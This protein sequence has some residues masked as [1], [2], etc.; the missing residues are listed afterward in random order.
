VHTCP[1]ASRSLEL[2]A[3]AKSNG[4]DIPEKRGLRLQ[5]VGFVKYGDA[6]STVLCS[7]DKELTLADMLA[8][9]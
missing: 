7:E 2:H 1:P 6:M 3:V 9:N 4:Q 8:D 5:K